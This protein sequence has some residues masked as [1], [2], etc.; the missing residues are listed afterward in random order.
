MLKFVAHSHRVVS[1]AKRHG[2]L[3]AARYTNLRDVK[4]FDQ[5]GFLDIAKIQK[6]SIEKFHDSILK[7]TDDIF[8][9]NDTV[10]KYAMELV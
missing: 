5:I 8:A 10:R 6:A 4:K 7:N 1:I 9:V 3:P 2:W